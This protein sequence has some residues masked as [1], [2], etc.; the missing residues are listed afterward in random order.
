MEDNTRRI[1]EQSF[2]PDEI[3][4]REGSFG[5]RLQ[6][7]EGQGVIARLNDA[8]AGDWSFTI[9][10]S[11]VDHDADEVIVHGRLSCAG[12]PE[13]AFGGSKIKRQRESREIVDLN[14]GYKAAATDSFKKAA[15]LLGVGLSLY[16]AKPTHQRR[17]DRGEHAGHHTSG[18]NQRQPSSG[19]I[20]GSFPSR[21]SVCIAHPYRCVRMAT[22]TPV[23]PVALFF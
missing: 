16:S 5:K 18:Q 21:F 7:V 23:T 22:A 19:N 14:S 11:F 15:T 3:K 17:E 2:R 6:Y 13:E 8:L 1:M 10:N 4:E 20:Q 12:I 9:V